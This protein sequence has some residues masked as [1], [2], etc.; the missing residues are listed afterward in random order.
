MS[1]YHSS[2]KRR[3]VSGTAWSLGGRIVAIF[4][5]M[6]ITALLS[7]LMTPSQMGV[8]F[9]IVSLISVVGTIS[10]LGLGGTGG[11][12][13]RLIA[14]AK[15]K[16]GEPAAKSTSLSILYLG[17]CGI[18]AVAV[19]LANG[20]GTWLATGV[21]R[22][23]LI[24]DH[25]TFVILWICLSSLGNLLAEIFRGYHNIRYAT[26]FSG[27]V[28]NV[29][30]AAMFTVM[31]L[32]SPVV[33]DIKYVLLV[34]NAAAAISV[35]MAVVLLWGM[36]KRTAASRRGKYSKIL[37]T[38][39]PLFVFSLAIIAMTQ[40]DLWVLGR[41]RPHEE[42]ALYGAAARLTM[43]VLTPLVILHS[44][45]P[46]LVAEMY[47]LEKRQELETVLRTISAIA[48][49]PAFLI[50]GCLII[51]G[52]WILGL[53]YGKYYVAGEDLLIILALGN[54]TLLSSGT[55]VVALTMTGHQLTL[56]AITLVTVAGMAIADFLVVNNYGAL[57]VA[58]VTAIGTFSYYLAIIFAVRI[59]V[60]VWSYMSVFRLRHI[61]ETLSMIASRV[62]LHTKQADS[63]P[64]IG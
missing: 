29:L 64:M 26:A 43:L 38:A 7:R 50:L 20:V 23:S 62:G 25:L 6:V 31:W 18:A 12:A 59:R 52:G 24:S 27:V 19:M 58:Y 42:V 51:G 36:L 41:Y 14:T 55:A 17:V 45:V 21:L 61:R 60:G 30:A 8:Y 10:L 46:P 53:V 22:A 1:E 39:G 13:V 49:I 16:H 57:G 33:T 34:A 11:A 56:L 35:L 47:V 44:V 4:T 28:F 3:L 5:S 40:L 32:L 9:L 48:G 15:A 37:S 63:E 2:L 54:V